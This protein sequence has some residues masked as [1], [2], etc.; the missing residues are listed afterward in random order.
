MLEEEE[1]RRRGSEELEI[2]RRI[3]I[4]ADCQYDI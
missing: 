3:R 2:K 4:T 1:T